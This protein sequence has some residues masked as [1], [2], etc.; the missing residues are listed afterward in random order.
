MT[1]TLRYSAGAGVP[2]DLDRLVASRLLVQAN[3]G[4]G[5]S[6]AIRQ[7]LEETH[8]RIQ[9]LVID[10]EGEF[11]TLRERFD[12]V[13]AAPKDGDVLATPKTG[14]RLCRGL[15]ELG[16]SAVL[17]IYDLALQ[18]RREFV[19]LFLMELMSL[20]RAL[21]RPLIVVIDEA[22]AFAPQTGESQALEGV[23]TLCTQGRKR[24]FCAVLATQRISKLHKDAAAELLNKLIG[25]TGLDVDVKRAGDELGFDKD[26]RDQLKFLSPG[27]FFVYGPAIANA[28]Q[29]ARTGD[30]KTSHPEAGRVSAAPPP[31]PER[32]RKVLAQLADLA[33]KAET[34]ARTIAD[35]DRENAVLRSQVRKLERGTLA[36]N[37]RIDQAAIDAA[38]AR[39]VA[40]TDRDWRVIFERRGRVLA[41]VATTLDRAATTI[42]QSASDLRQAVELPVPSANGHEPAARR[43]DPAPLR[44][45]APVSRN[46]HSA[47]S[48]NGAL[49]K[50]PRRMVDAL[51]QLASLGVDEPSREN[52][53]GWVGISANTGTFRNY[54]SELRA[55]EAIEDLADGRL[56][57]TETGQ[58]LTSGQLPI[59][60]LDALHEVWSRKLGR[61]PAGMLAVLIEAYPEPVSRADLG[62]AV[63]ISHETGT[64]RNYLS[65]LR[66]PGIMRDVSRTHVAATELLFPPGLS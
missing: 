16:A 58:A 3:S 9:H 44:D 10:P 46:G 43:N 40:K 59:E 37:P 66:S 30:V 26:Q 53:A 31:P 5:K 28:V 61:T 63:G 52:V 25:R 48:S 27:E 41:Q 49:G 11:S 29:K 38:V 19:K 64:F 15:M 55:N 7:L 36:A 57:L 4:G 1:P 22:H 60:S 42:T 12:Y 24:G 35:L 33:Q 47:P 34:E 51:A 56:R 54:L 8:G 50:T 18:D 2:V 65:V 23:T 14:R 6:R 20:P 39:V 13:L 32:V 45:V 62:A 17:D 21:W